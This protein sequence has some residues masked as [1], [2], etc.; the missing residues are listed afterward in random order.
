MNLIKK[1]LPTKFYRE[2]INF[3]EK[4]FTGYKMKSY[5]Q[6]GEDI[7]LLR[8]FDKKKDGF[9]VDVGAHHPKR[10]S[11]TYLFYKMGWK[12]INIEPRPGSKKLFNKVRPR[13]INL[14]LAISDSAQ[15]LNY[16]IFNDPA[17][18][19]FDSNLS[20]LYI[21]NSKYKIIDNK[22]LNTI[23]LSDVLDKYLPERIKINILSIDTEG[24]DFN[25][26][27]SNDGQKFTPEII[28]VEEGNFDLM[29]PSKSDIYNFLTERNY[30]LFSKTFNT[31]IFI[32]NKV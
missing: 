10:F 30:S 3:Y 31:L 17:L 9:Y 16:Y 12:G 11:N 22:S 6:E 7:I 28:L 25:V 5:A 1:I 27:K 4:Y 24:F 21:K 14:E 20:E 13:D 2:L 15:N 19:T 8:Y 26:L 23:K 32:Y 29:Q 18:K